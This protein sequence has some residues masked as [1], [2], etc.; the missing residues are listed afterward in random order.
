MKTS[1]IIT[2]GEQMKTIADELGEDDNPLQ[3]SEEFRKKV[4]DLH[5]PELQEKKLLRECDGWLKCRLVLR[6]A[7]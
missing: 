6:K 2:C 3:E 5:L 1:G 4:M 7:A